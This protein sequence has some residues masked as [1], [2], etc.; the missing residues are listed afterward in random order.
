MPMVREGATVTVTDEKKLPPLPTP[1]LVKMVKQQR[2]K[3][4][5]AKQADSE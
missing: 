3:P 5:S 1:E 2:H 4:D